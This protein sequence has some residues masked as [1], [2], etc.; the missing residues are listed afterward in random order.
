MGGPRPFSQLDDWQ[1]IS[2]VGVALELYGSGF[3]VVWELRG[4]GFGVVW[5]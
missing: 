1:V 2:G 4:R 5:E 3:G